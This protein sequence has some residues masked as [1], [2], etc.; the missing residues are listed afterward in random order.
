M[1]VIV[2]VVAIIFSFL[3]SPLTALGFFGNKD[4]NEG[5]EF[6]RGSAL[7]KD[8]KLAPEGRTAAMEKALAIESTLRK[9]SFELTLEYAFFMHGKQRFEVV[10]SQEFDISKL[11]YPI[12]GEILILKGE[13]GFLSK[14][15]LGGKYGSSEFKKTT[16]SDEDWGLY[17]LTWPNGIDN[18][19][20]YQITKQDCK[21]KVYFF[22]V[23]LYYRLLAFNRDQAKE[24]FL[25][26]IYVREKQLWDY[27]QLDKLFFDIFAGYQ[28]QRG[29]YNMIDP[30]KEWLRDDEGTSYFMAGLPANINLDSFYKIE[31]KGPRVGLRAGTQGKLNTKFSFA[32]AWLKTDAYGWWN[33]RNY[34][35]QQS[36]ENGGGLDIELEAAYKFTPRLCAG[37][38]YNYFYYQQKK[39]KESGV[40][41]GYVYE[42]LDIIRNANC[43]IYG[44]SFILKY[45]W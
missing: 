13:I 15:F 30:L 29:R 8:K 3:N 17:D 20:D 21:S 39:M 24:R 23:N 43:K 31:Y 4:T 40:Q 22:D 6:N 45:I 19:V 33:L 14:I 16:C 41:P 11:I 38:G 35:F 1:R 27:I 44:P 37:L 28:S 9:L 25:P 36:G 12:K 32:Y 2:L 34:S 10:N 7:Q 18:Y 42:D 26:S 5:G